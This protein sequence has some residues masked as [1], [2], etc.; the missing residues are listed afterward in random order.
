MITDELRADLYPQADEVGE[1][2]VWELPL[3]EIFAAPGRDPDAHHGGFLTVDGVFIGVATARQDKHNHAGPFAPR[4][5][6]C[7]GCRWFEPRIFRELT[8]KRRYVMYTLGCSNM[9]GESDR[10]RYRYA[11]DAFE[12]IFVMSTEKDDG[13]G[14]R[15]L[16]GPAQRMFDMAAQQDPEIA[17]ALESQWSTAAPVAEDRWQS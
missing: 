3:G 11:N 16:S 13:S 5:R 14:A 7:P 1:E 8:G 2:A 9:P 15:F 17:H 4:E 6:R 12:A 10:P